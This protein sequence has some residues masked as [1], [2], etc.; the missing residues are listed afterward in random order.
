MTLAERYIENETTRQQ[1]LN[2]S[3][4]EMAL[5]FAVFSPYTL[6]SRTHHLVARHSSSPYP[7]GD[8]QIN[9][10]LRSCSIAKVPLT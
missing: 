1:N 8:A 4:A 9:G 3:I 2:L 7:P 5:F 6:H 10:V